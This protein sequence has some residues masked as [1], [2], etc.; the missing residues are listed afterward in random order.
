MRTFGLIGFPLS[1]SFSAQFF[2][3]KF[4]KESIDDA[5]YQLFPIENISKISGIIDSDPSLCGLN[6]T[7]PYKQS[8]M[9]LLDYVDPAAFEI[10][11]VNC[12]SINRKNRE[13]QLMGY[14]TDVFGFEKSLLPMLKPWHSHALVF[15]NGGA[16]KAVT[17][18]L[19]KLKIEYQLVSRQSNM[20]NYENIDSSILAKYTLLINTTP[21]GMHPNTESAPA[22]PYQFLTNKHLVYDLVYNPK[23]TQFLR[24]AFEYGATTKNGLEMLYLQAEKSWYIWNGE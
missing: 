8:I 22:I 12:I 9:P 3:E 13:I 18:V 1:H 15:G 24:N 7:I 10:G 5:Y 14:N 6:V 2:S 23:E 20:M 11:A 16:A 21:L 19:R 17:Y 4:Q